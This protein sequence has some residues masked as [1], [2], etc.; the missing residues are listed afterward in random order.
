[1][2][3]GRLGK[4]NSFVNDKGTAEVP[5]GVVNSSAIDQNMHISVVY[6]YIYI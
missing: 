5:S 6:R 1:M 4:K 2:K 3:R